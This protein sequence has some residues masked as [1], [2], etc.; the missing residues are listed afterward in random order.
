MR[1]RKFVSRHALYD[2]IKLKLEAEHMLVSDYE[3]IPYGIQ[4]TVSTAGNELK[5]RVYESKKKGVSLDVSQV[6]KAG[7]GEEVL[8]LLQEF[9]PDDKRLPSMSTSKDSERLIGIDECGKG[10]YF[11]PLVISAVFLDKGLRK[12]LES[13]GI[14]DSKRI[15][16]KKILPLA[17]E[18]R[19]ICPHE[20]IVVMPEHYNRMYYRDQNLNVLL[21]KGH[22][23]V[24]EKMLGKV[25]CVDAL[26][27]QFAKEHVLKKQLGPLASDITLHQRPRAEANPSVAAASV[28]ARADFLIAMKQME[29]KWSFMFPKGAGKQVNEAAVAFAGMFGKDHM[30]EVAKLHFKTSR[31]VFG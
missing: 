6:K 20:S 18:I 10:D 31:L 27:D 17:D 29:H 23:A 13:T 8:Q 4:F 26:S 25:D 28:I 1:H 16:D 14:Q 30:H 9:L 5:L 7:V 19:K 24:L 12:A 22:A 15:S 11:G 2:A 3:G 21:A